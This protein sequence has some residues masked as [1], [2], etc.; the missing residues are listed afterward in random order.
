MF[1]TTSE[2]EGE[3]GAIKHVFI[4]GR[5]KAVVLLWFYDACFGVRVSMTFHLLCVHIILVRFGL[6]SS[7]LLGKSCSLGRPYGLVVF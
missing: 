4:T 6:L 5:S 7:H 3:V 1:C 2:T